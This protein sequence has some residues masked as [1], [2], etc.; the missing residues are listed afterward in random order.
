MKVPFVIAAKY[1]P[2]DLNLVVSSETFSW[3]KRKNLSQIKILRHL[4]TGTL[5]FLWHCFQNDKFT[6]DSRGPEKKHISQ[7]VKL[8]SLIA[9][10]I[11]T[12]R[13]GTCTHFAWTRPT[14]NLKHSL[15]CPLFQWQ[16]LM[17]KSMSECDMPVT[18][19]L[20]AIA[21]SLTSPSSSAVHVTLSHSPSFFLV[22]QARCG[23]QVFITI[24]NS[25]TITEYCVLCCCVNIL[26]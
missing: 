6:P 14:S 15:Q 10:H 18:M 12:L 7:L 25:C 3:Q 16:S 23:S 20:M 5:L 2:F 1:S 4:K 26:L 9:K 21:C 13:Q 17:R 19:C 24:T 22:M 8:R 11:E